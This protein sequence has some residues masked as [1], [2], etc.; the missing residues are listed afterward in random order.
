MA[1]SAD[2]SFGVGLTSA[3]LFRVTSGVDESIAL[4]RLKAQ[5]DALQ[6]I[7]DATA[8]QV[9]SI[10]RDP[11]YT[12]Q[13][14]LTR[15]RSE[16]DERAREVL[17]LR[18]S[19]RF[20][21]R[22]QLKRAG[23]R[24]EAKYNEFLGIDGDAP[25][26]LSL[27]QELEVRNVLRPILAEERGKQQIAAIVLDAAASG[28][29]QLV[30]AVSRD[31]FHQFVDGP[32]LDKALEAL[33]EATDPSGRRIVLAD[34]QVGEVMEHN[35]ASALEAIAKISNSNVAQAKTQEIRTERLARRN[36]PHSI[37]DAPVIAA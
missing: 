30:R 5:A 18:A 25:T 37:T 35:V 21:D 27:M 34:E 11:Q 17:A 9:R 10:A 6:G 14:R 16:G 19:D 22:A 8:A 28:N 36:D 1:S 23:E 4:D 20:N 32:T 15:A 7:I 33:W 13:G 26:V 31:P 29:V 3:G 24:R 2:L 12:P